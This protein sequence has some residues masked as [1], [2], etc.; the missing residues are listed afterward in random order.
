M[1]TRASCMMNAT[2]FLIKFLKALA[3]FVL[4]PI[5]QTLEK[6]ISYKSYNFLYFECILPLY[7]K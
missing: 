1:V 7:I 2:S 4:L 3:L 5:Q 6:A